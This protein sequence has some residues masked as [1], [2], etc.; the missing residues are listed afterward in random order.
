MGHS[1][2][3]ELYEGHESTEK[4]LHIVVFATGTSNVMYSVM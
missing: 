4:R 2:H 1:E 3:L